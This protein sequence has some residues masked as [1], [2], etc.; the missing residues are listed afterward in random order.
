MSERERRYQDRG[1]DPATLSDAEIR[2]ELDWLS[3][4]KACG[5][6]EWEIEAR[7]WRLKFEIRFREQ[8]NG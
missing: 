1:A 4:T 2:K 6:R 3:G 7:K 5:F 8:G